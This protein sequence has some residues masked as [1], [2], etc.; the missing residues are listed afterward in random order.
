MT[1]YMNN[2]QTDQTDEKK[3]RTRWAVGC[4]VSAIAIVCIVVFLALGGFAGLIAL[5]GGDPEGLT[6]EV[7]T[8]T[9]KIYV[10]E[11]FTISLDLTN[12][13]NQNIT[14]KEIQLP[15]ELLEIALVT[16]VEPTSE[17]GLDYGDQ[18][19][20]E[21]DM[22]IAPTGQEKIVFTFEALVAGDISGDLDVSVGTKSK[23]TPIRV[24][25][26]SA[27]ASNGENDDD[28]LGDIIPFRSVV[29]IIAIVEIEGERVEG[30]SG[31]GTII[32]EDG[33]ILTN[34]HVVLSERYYDVVDL[35][36]SIT[37]AQD[38]PPE[39]MFYADVLQADANLDLA[40]IKIRSDLQGNPANFS[41][42][43]IEPV[44]LGSS[45]SLRLGD[46]I[47]IIGYPGIGGETI[48]LTRGEVSGF[49]AEDPYGNRAFIKTSAVIAGGNSGGLAATAQGKIIGVPTQVGSGD[50]ED[51][52]VDCRPLADT[53]RDG[54]IDDKDTCV[55]TGGFINALRPITLAL[56]MIEA[57]Q[58]GE[59]AIEEG[60][61]GQSQEE[62]SP[63]GNVIL[64]EDFSDNSNDWFIGES[65]DGR[66]DISG[67]KL[68]IDVYTESYVVWSDLPE[69]YNSALMVTNAQALNPVGDGDFGFVCGMEDSGN[70]T[71][72]EISEDGYYA[73]WKYENDQ[74]VS[75]VDW[76]YSNAL[77]QGGVYTLAAYCGPDKLYLAVNN[78]LLVETVDPNFNPG[79]IGLIAGCFQNPNIRLGFEDFIVYQP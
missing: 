41:D 35:V 4:G 67:G 57:A 58:T 69:T 16:D 13:G 46:E 45:D 3:R 6:L 2:D 53:N 11:T 22:T 14:I 37:T 32:S 18:T 47:I 40:V 52:V 71:A 63:Q 26:S 12:Q 79:R 70:F 76:T 44:P 20:Y 36:V 74:F 73:I 60:S 25:I 68:L 61:E 17:Q 55:P 19:A 48:T 38:R 33:L 28:I 5:F 30:W 64:S 39:P 21:F 31:S 54:Y 51:M 66:A 10:G 15:N 27:S 59:V 8:P 7:K 9:S 23:T 29:Q 49:T 77:P 78:T 62:Y 65:S 34:A 1:T 72:L 24:V 56:P 75:L 43:D 42:L 50:I